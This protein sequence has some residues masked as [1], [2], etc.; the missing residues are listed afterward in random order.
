MLY[1]G[2]DFEMMEDLDL[3][4]GREH[5]WVAGCWDRKDWRLSCWL[6]VC[7]VV[8]LVWVWRKEDFGS[9]SNIMAR[10]EKMLTFKGLKYKYLLRTLWFSL[11]S[12]RWKFFCFVLIKYEKENMARHEIFSLGAEN[13]YYRIRILI[14]LSFLHIFFSAGKR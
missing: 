11:E 7:S 5:R 3:D 4:V 10:S 13:H 14:A 6:G 12:Q 9:E 1:L 2:E 8:K